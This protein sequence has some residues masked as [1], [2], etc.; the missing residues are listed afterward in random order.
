MVRAAFI[1]CALLVWP[2]WAQGVPR[3]TP[4]EQGIDSVKLAEG[5]TAMREQGIDVHSLL[6]IRNGVVVVDAYFYPY[7]GTYVH[8][9]ASETKSVTTTL[10]GIAVDQGQ[11]SLDTPVL[12]FFPGRTIADRDARKERMTVR[13]L[14]SMTSGFDCPRSA[15]E[16]LTQEMLAA[17]DPVQFAL[18]RRMAAE[19][20]TEFAYCN[21]ASHLLSAILERTT[22]RTALDFAREYLFEP[23]DIHEVMWPTDSQGVHRGW[24]DLHLYPSDMAKIGLLWLQG[25]LWHGEPIVSRTW[26]EAS[27]SHQV[28]SDSDDGYGLGWW[29]TAGASPGEYRADGRSGQFTIVLPTLNLVVQTTGGGLEGAAL[30]PAL[31]PALVDMEEPLP[32][33]PAGVARLE[34]VVAMVARPPEPEPVPSLPDAAMEVTGR[35]IVFEP[36]PLTVE[37]IRLDFD[38]SAECRW[39]I[40]I[41]GRQEPLSGRMGLDGVYRMSLGDGGLPVGVRGAWADTRTFVFEYDEIANLDAYTLRLHFDHGRVSI[42]VSDREGGAFSTTGRVE[43]P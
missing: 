14:A 1:V 12:S 43:N 2:V 22:G 31:L 26:V 15:N 29:L 11:L 19:P 20:G 32:A 33:N 42:D 21:L 30:G 41:A 35:T 36:N 27:V 17:P 6:M 25:G 4:E 3:G 34:S 5:L 40:T 24:G 7:D 37:T 8:D 10:I 23:L 13:H 16:P 38:G 18:D 28:D 39:R 9:L